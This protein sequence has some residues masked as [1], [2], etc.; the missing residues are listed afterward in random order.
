MKTSI[1][2]IG[3]ASKS[4]PSGSEPAGVW[5]LDAAQSEA[6]AKALMEPAAPN[7]ALLAAAARYRA[8][9]GMTVAE[10]RTL[11]DGQPDDARVLVFDHFEPERTTTIGA[12]CILSM[13]HNGPVAI[14]CN[15]DEG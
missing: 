14:I 9:H 10:L 13:D 5:C 15:Q 1:S 3:S 12:N 4:A 8:K 11:L 2:Q 7:A 6:F